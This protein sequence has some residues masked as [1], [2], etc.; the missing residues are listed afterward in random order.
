M[1]I[2]ILILLLSFIVFVNLC[3]LTIGYIRSE[4]LYMKY[5]KQILIG[6]ASFIFIVLAFYIALALIGLN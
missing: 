3:I 1:V 5:G 2:R 4:N 6:F